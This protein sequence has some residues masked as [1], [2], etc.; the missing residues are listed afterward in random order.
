MSY[1]DRRKCPQILVLASAIFMVLPVRGQ[2]DVLTQHNDNARSGA[3][4]KETTL[5]PSNVDKANFGKLASRVVDGDVYAQPLVVSGSLIAGRAAPTNVVIVA[6]ENNSV[7]A[8]DAEDTL[9]ASTQALLWHT[10]PAILGEHIE[11]RELYARIG[12]P[13]CSDLTT[14]IGITGTPAIQ[15]N[16]QEA[17]KEGT[18]FVAAKSKSGSGYVYKLFALSLATGEQ[19]GAVEI[20]GAVAGAGIGSTGGGANKAIEFD[21]MYELNRPALLLNGNT[22][23]IAFGGHCDQGPYHGWVMAYDV[24]DPKAPKSVGVFCSTPNGKGTE[25]EGRAGIWMSGDGPA[26]DD[27]GNIY[28]VTG[29]GTNNASTDF[30]DSVVKASLDDAGKFQVKDWYTPNNQEMLKNNDVDL[31]SGGAALIPNTHLLMVGGKEGRAYLIDRDRMGKGAATSLQ[32]FQVTQ[33]PQPPNYYCLHGTPVVWARPNQMFV[34]FNGEE[35]PV[36][37]YRLVPTTDE[38][39]GWRFESDQPYKKSSDC[40]T[41]PQCVS[42]PFPNSVNKTSGRPRKENIWMP[43]GFMS[44]SANGSEDGSGI[45]WVAMPYGANA[46]HA[47]V[48][49]VLRALDASDL[50]K[51]ELWNSEGT[52]DDNDRLGLFAKFCPPTVANGKVYV[53]TFEQET[54]GKDGIHR[55][56]PGGDQAAVAIYGLK[57]EGAGCGDRSLIS[58][59][60]GKR[61][62]TEGTE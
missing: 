1:P 35:D 60:N 6:T 7:Y 53:A 30:G 15:I 54:I 14:K 25:Q 39:G 52:G 31:G 62:N 10:G 48:R 11:S 9:Q 12:T 26:A 24:S 56:V 43:G 38:S 42:A 16:R 4:L 59:S 40:P 18:I 55:L 29:D 32:S 5:N 36:K 34:Y 19:I 28:F 27:A 50:S 21:A 22:L 33:D 37:Q 44:I 51:P 41:A 45:L 23:Y 58:E 2:V 61:I 13:G 46:N 20:Q 47:V 3:N 17:P 57:C 8:F 49:G